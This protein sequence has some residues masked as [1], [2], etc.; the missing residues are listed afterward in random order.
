[1]R[2]FIYY[3]FPPRRKELRWTSFITPVLFPLLFG[4]TCLLLELT[5]KLLFT[6]PAAFWLVLILPWFWWMIEN[7]YSGLYGFRQIIAVWVRL[8]I[9]GIFIMLLAEPRA[10]RESKALSVV[11]TLD[12]SDSI[13]DDA[14]T[15][16]LEYVVSTVHKKPEAD[17]AGL[18]VF[19]KDA[20][21]E[22]PPRVTFPFEAVNSLI[23]R[24]DTNIEK[25]LLLSAA[26]IPEDENGRIV[27]ITDGNETSGAVKNALDELKSRSIM[28]DVLPVQFNF[29]KEV[30]LEKLE[31]PVNVKEGET[32]DASVILSALTPGK[33]RLV[34]E[35][36]GQ[37]IFEKDVQYNAGKNRFTI[38][39]YLR[40]PG[41]YEY[42]ARID[43]PK[44]EDGWNKNNIAINYIYLRGKGKVLFL[45]D[46]SGDKREWE[47]IAQTIRKSGR[48]VEVKDA[49]D[50][51]RDTMTMMPYDCV[52]MVNVSADMFDIVQLNAIRD[53]VYSQGTGLLMVGGRNS[54]GPGGY[55]RTPID[56][57]LPVDMDISTKKVL[58]KGALAI[59]LHTCEFENGN[60]W[61]KRIAK[62]AIRVLG[63]QDE[64]GLL[65]W[66][67]KV[68]EGWIFPLTPV[69]QYE[70]M[71][72]KI[73][74]CEPGDM[75]A[76]GTTM[77]LGL[78]GLKK[79][80]A[81][82]KHMIIISDGDPQP[83]TP[84]LVQEFVK[85]E[86]S[87][88]TVLVDGY[89]QGSFQNV[90]KALASTTG[91]RFYYPQN[92][93]ALPSIFI[94]EAK[95]LKKSMIQNKTFTPKVEFDDGSIL[96]GIDTMPP[97]HGYVLTTPK[98]DSRR[99]S[100]VLRGPDTDQVDPVLA[101]GRFGTGKSAAFTSDLSP[102]WAKDWMQWDKLEAFVKQLVVNIS[103][104]SM[105]SSLRMSSYCSGNTG[106]VT[107]EDFHPQEGFLEIMAKIK[108]PGDVGLDLKLEQVGPRRYQGKFDLWGEGR[109]QIFAAGVGDKRNDTVAG[110]LVV[111]YSAEYLRFKSNPAVIEKIAEATGGRIL[112]GTETG[113]E[114]FVKERKTRRSSKPV[115]E[116]FLVLLACL[117]PLDVGIRRVQIDFSVLM[118]FFRRKKKTGESTETLGSLL[119]RKKDVD[120]K[121][122]ESVKD[123][124]I[125]IPKPSG[126]TFPAKPPPKKDEPKQEKKSEE[127]PEQ[128]TEEMSMTERLLAKKRKK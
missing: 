43:V 11:Y 31:L 48:E 74:N 100:V 105:E 109:Y 97:L 115:F 52:V 101:V 61:A 122:E 119:K 92:P 25:S 26:M 18:I 75:P 76:F 116:I 22:L 120:A 6:K 113:D 55:H 5:G 79:S 127:K 15:K 94:K 32:Y 99:C 98:S 125:S 102:N 50:C 111:P 1:M 64:A 72:K 21:V 36:N 17:K 118:G 60:T 85:A 126:R 24:D 107:V 20:A 71:V 69:S 53:A 83:P 65:A 44:G 59:I 14:S 12:I 37:T 87:V 29:G 108:G 54:F 117:I 56:E 84:E 62:A 66:D 16:A 7:G 57:A 70:D 34:L 96:K 90:M 8:S 106:V 19:G 86:I 73:N 4:V 123:M 124:Q 39:I 30:W 89:H 82:T 63:E 77:K 58:P 23:S 114:I 38:P 45:R 10:V 51:P 41:Y 68:G 13:A 28:V 40:T 35:E 93:E 104:V 49:I 81:A 42:N 47:L 2:N 88:S 9:A 110:G 80:D 128:K 46:P 27:L 78:E 103:R 91:G 95:T 67:Y 121:M 3:I 33:G 112:T